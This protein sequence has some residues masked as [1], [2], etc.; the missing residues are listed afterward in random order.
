[1]ANRA[2]ELVK[3]VQDKDKVIFGGVVGSYNFGLADGKSDNDVRFYVF[4]TMSDLVRRRMTRMLFIAEESD[5]QVHDIRRSEYMFS[6]GDANQLSILFSKELYIN[7]KYK[8]FVMPL[9]ERREELVE[10]C[11][12]NIYSWA[13]SMFDKKMGQLHYF[14]RNEIVYEKFGYNTKAAGQ[15]IYHL[16]L[17]EKYFHNLEYRIDKPFE[18]AMD[19]SDIRD[20]VID[21]RNGKYSLEEFNEIADAALTSYNSI[22]NIKKNGFSAAPSWYINS[23]YNACA[24]YCR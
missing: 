16:K 4:P 18:N 14:K 20:L 15:A 5:I 3:Y 8:D 17:I 24:K 10:R 22:Q 23:M 7:P 6:M 19:C 12:A 21:I 2:E 1:M 11:A 13:L 9:I